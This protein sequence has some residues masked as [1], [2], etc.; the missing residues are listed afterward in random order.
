M[1][2][3][4]ILAR[5]P[6]AGRGHPCGRAVRLWVARTVYGLVFGVVL[7]MACHAHLPIQDP[8]LAPRDV[9]QVFK[10]PLI[11]GASVSA[12]YGTLSPGRSASLRYTEPSRIQVMAVT[13]EQALQ[14]VAAAFL[15]ET[16]APSVLI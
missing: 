9:A 5:R 16:C 7:I 13:N 15:G 10:T 12:D 14:H 3:G 6:A 8:Q 2:G 11:L 1:A 4:A